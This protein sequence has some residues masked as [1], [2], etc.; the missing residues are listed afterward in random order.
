MTLPLEK[1]ND[2]VFY[3]TGEIVRLDARAVDFVRAQ[4]TRNARGRARICTHRNADEPLH[5]MLIAVASSSYIRPH[6]HHGKSESFH[7]VDGEADVVVLNDDGEIEDVVELGPAG[8]FYYRLD[9]PRYHTLVLHSPVLV[10]HEI[11]NGPFTP[12][13]S[14]SAPFA[15]AEGESGADGYMR[16]LAA[17]VANWKEL[18]GVH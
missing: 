12:G 5:E 17:R 2:E 8:N 14:D 13:A 11:T 10:I 16:D 18:H 6:R 15:P 9:A 7:L 1:I 3:A 4:A